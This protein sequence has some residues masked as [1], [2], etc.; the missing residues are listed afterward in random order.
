MS[1]SEAIQNFRYLLEELILFLKNNS[2]CY[3]NTGDQINDCSYLFNR[4]FAAT[5]N[6]GGQCP[7]GN[8]DL[9]DFLQVRNEPDMYVLGYVSLS[10]S[11]SFILLILIDE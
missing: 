9:N 1:S 5:W 10:L 8:L 11:L 2:P 6:V 4:V 7:T 3:Y